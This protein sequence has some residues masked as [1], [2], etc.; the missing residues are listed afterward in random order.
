MLTEVADRLVR[1][2]DAVLDE[3]LLSILVLLCS[4]GIYCLWDAVHLYDSADP[5]Q[6]RQYRPVREE[7][8][9]SLDELKKS[10]KDVIGWISVNGTGIDYPLVQGKTNTEYLSL[11]AEGRRASSGSI[12][13]DYRNS[14]Y[15]SDFS[16]VIYGHHMSHGSMF[17]DI[18]LYTDRDF[19]EMHRRGEL[20]YFRED[21]TLLV[22]K[23]IEFF[24]FSACIDGYD[25]RVY[26]LKFDND[27]EKKDYIDYITS[28]ADYVI[29]SVADYKDKLI[30][31][32]TCNRSM[33]NGRYILVGMLTEPDTDIIQ[34][35]SSDEEESAVPVWLYLLFILLGISLIF[36]LNKRAH[37]NK[38]K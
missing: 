27:E 17:G 25:D 2:L 33:T 10:N 31:L 18:D 12:Y 22:H 36:V 9:I 4:V 13:L 15:F 37:L 20:Y 19:F 26:G 35:M 38:R 1:C 5:E 14:P 16:S 23:E 32:S 21:S 34:T 29:S 3:I 24:A 6:Y 28:N 11:N 30:I 7:D 8:S